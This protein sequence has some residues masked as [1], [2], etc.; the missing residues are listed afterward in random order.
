MGYCAK[1]TDIA[2]LRSLKLRILNL[3]G[4]GV[5]DEGIAHFL[6][7]GAGS[8]LEDIDLSATKAEQSN[9]ITD[10]TAQLIGVSSNVDRYEHYVTRL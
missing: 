4:T 7:E 10:A 2:P 5:T 8:L 3:H 1:L 9:S 6:N